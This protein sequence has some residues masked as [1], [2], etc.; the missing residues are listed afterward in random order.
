MCVCT[1]DDVAE[2]NKEDNDSVLPASK[3]WYPIHSEDKQ[4]VSLL[5][6]Y[7]MRTYTYFLCSHLYCCV[8]QMSFSKI[9]DCMKFIL[10]IFMLKILL[11]VICITDVIDDFSF[12]FFLDAIKLFYMYTD[13]SAAFTN[14]KSICFLPSR[15]HWFLL[16]ISGLPSG[17]NACIDV[18]I[19]KLKNEVT[20]KLKQNTY[21]FSLA[22]DMERF[23][24]AYCTM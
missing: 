5:N 23:K 8:N 10:K 22:T 7:E 4:S 21:L 16:Y 13:L 1:K 2:K 18:V 14:I 24:F 19:Y 12:S 9:S 15:F 20:L 6:T 17:I 3:S 11:V